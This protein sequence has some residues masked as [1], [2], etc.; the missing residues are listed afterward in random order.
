MKDEKKVRSTQNAC[1][2]WKELR[3]CPE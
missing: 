2:K 1:N 3:A